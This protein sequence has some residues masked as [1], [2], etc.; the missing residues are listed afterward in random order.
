MG[1]KSKKTSVILRSN[2]KPMQEVSLDTPPPFQDVD[3]SIEEGRSGDMGEADQ[4][5]DQLQQPMETAPANDLNSGF[6]TPEDLGILQTDSKPQ[7]NE[8]RERKEVFFPPAA[9]TTM[10]NSSDGLECKKELQEDLLDK[11]K[12]IEKLRQMSLKADQEEKEVANLQGQLDSREADLKL[13]HKRLQEQDDL[14]Q[15]CENLRKQFAECKISKQ[16]ATKEAKSYKN[17]LEKA[18]EDLETLQKR[19]NGIE[20]QLSDLADVNAKLEREVADATEELK[21]VKAQGES[22]LEYL[23]QQS[24]Q[25]VAAITKDFEEREVSH[26]DKKDMKE[27]EDQLHQAQ[28]QQQEMKEEHRTSLANALK[29]KETAVAELLRARLEIESQHKSY[30]ENQK[31]I[32]QYQA[33]LEAERAT[34]QHLTQL[35]QTALEQKERAWTEVRE[36]KKEVE[37]LTASILHK[38]QSSVKRKSSPELVAEDA[39]RA[40]DVK[41]IENAIKVSLH[42]TEEGKAGVEEP[43]QEETGASAQEPAIE[44]ELEKPGVPLPPPTTTPHAVM[45]KPEPIQA[46]GNSNQ[47]A[48]RP[49]WP[50]LDTPDHSRFTGRMA[51]AQVI[52]VPLH[53]RMMDPEK[54]AESYHCI[55]ML[56]DQVSYHHRLIEQALPQLV[57]SKLAWDQHGADR[58]LLVQVARFLA[59]PRKPLDL[60]AAL[61]DMA[62][63]GPFP[64]D[65]MKEQIKQS[66]ARWVFPDMTLGSSILLKIF[67]PAARHYRRYAI[68]FLLILLT[69][70]YHIHFTKLAMLGGNIEKAC[71]FLFGPRTGATFAQTSLHL[72]VTLATAMSTALHQPDSLGMPATNPAGILLVDH[73]GSPS[74]DH[75]RLLQSMTG[76]KADIIDFINT[77]SQRSYMFNDVASHIER[78][79]KPSLKKLFNEEIRVGGPSLRTFYHL[80]RLPPPVHQGQI[81]PR[82][83]QGAARRKYNN[84]Y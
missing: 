4:L 26:Q 57:D 75:L 35:H 20:D 53:A 60:T 71:S 15:E 61:R 13:L 3:P 18:M 28:E 74:T 77:L 69:P 16:T 40:R 1:K 33:L 62:E 14:Q 10:E 38:A 59:I 42:L 83:Y 34:A 22:K 17:K 12:L 66:A 48:G 50:L 79:E 81:R 39:K 30:S 63:A 56:R 65:E 6:I 49:N 8:D 45:G 76:F 68:R 43:M 24:E 5:L 44:A 54:L 55:T 46:K 9:I 25:Q 36:L 58:D 7:K 47:L 23:K 78:K 52:T 27:I 84:D 72:L 29:E 32:K 70:A 41:H 64:T 51:V 11:E 37:K 21:I 31:H 2:L 80:A 19:V 73:D 82:G 67:D